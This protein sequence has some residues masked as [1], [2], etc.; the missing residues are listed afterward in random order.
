MGGRIPFCILMR[1]GFGGFSGSICWAMLPTCRQRATACQSWRRG[2]LL[3]LLTGR[4]GE[5]GRT[6]LVVLC[7]SSGVKGALLRLLSFLSHLTLVSAASFSVL[8]LFL[9]CSFA[10]ECR[11]GSVEAAPPLPSALQP[12]P[13]C[14][15]ASAEVI[16]GMRAKLDF[17][18]RKKSQYDSEQNRVVVFFPAKRKWS[19]HSCFLTT[20]Q[21]C[22][23]ANNV[24]LQR[25]VDGET[26]GVGEERRSDR[27]S[28]PRTGGDDS[29]RFTPLPVSSLFSVLTPRL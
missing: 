3:S 6:V 1:C 17:K 13:K 8:S 15:L 7:V 11:V 9:K 21:P 27:C 28:C 5:R 14:V 18:R 22:L 25:V 23:A 10:E 26:D 24:Y 20:T 2:A 19:L 4:E 16:G 12:P 29:D